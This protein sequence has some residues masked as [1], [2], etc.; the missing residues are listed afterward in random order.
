MAIGKREM[1]LRRVLRGKT[2]KKRGKR[3]DKAKGEEQVT[4]TKKKENLVS[5]PS[6]LRGRCNLKKKKKKTGTIEGKKKLRGKE[7]EGG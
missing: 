6:R 1:W 2:K 3:C 4:P 5:G 7:R